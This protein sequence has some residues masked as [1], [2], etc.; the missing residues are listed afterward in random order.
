MPLTERASSPIDRQRIIDFLKEIFG[1]T[2]AAVALDPGY[3]QWKYWAPHPLFGGN[4]SQVI[5]KEGKLLAH[6][7]IWPIQLVTS[8]GRPMCF[9]LVDWAAR[10]DAQGTGMRVLRRCGAGLTA[11]FSI[12]GTAISQQI[13]LLAGFKSYNRMWFLTWPPLSRRAVREFR[14]FD[15][16]APARLLR[17]LVRYARWFFSRKVSRPAGCDVAILE[18]NEVPES[19]WPGALPKLAVSMRSPALLEHVS[20]CPVIAKS[21]CC[22][23][24]RH[25]KPMAY[26]FLI[27]VGKQVRLADYGP[28]GLDEQTGMMVG[29]AAL[30]LAKTCFPGTTEFMAATSEP[31]VLAGL[32]RA[33]LRLRGEELIRVRKAGTELEQIDC[34]RLTLMDSDTLCL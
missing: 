32:L 23:L 18:P 3:L 1:L 12:G 26:L 2:E 22:A 33:G 4:R 29:Q 11:Q 34:F 14:L 5:E 19:L 10:P 7:C 21:L 30:Q 6:G 28:A 27:Q 15:K 8:S 17:F 31:D 20:R 16:R 25:S 9:H 24:Y 13:L